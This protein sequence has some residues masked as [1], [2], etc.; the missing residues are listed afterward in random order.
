MC[1]LRSE[2]LVPC[3]WGMCRSMR[4]PW[5]IGISEIF[6]AMILVFLFPLWLLGPIWHWQNQFLIVQELNRGVGK[7]LFMVIF[8][9]SVEN[10]FIELCV[11]VFVNVN[12]FRFAELPH[13]PMMQKLPP[14]VTR[15]TFYTFASRSFAEF[16]NVVLHDVNHTQLLICHPG[17]I[18]GSS[19]NFWIGSL[20]FDQRC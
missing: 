10:T 15:G 9:I 2:K 1:L 13:F 7:W 19:S 17:V 3:T 18:W 20:Y 4:S 16:G 12:I 5:S 14:N 6:S 8:V 11:L